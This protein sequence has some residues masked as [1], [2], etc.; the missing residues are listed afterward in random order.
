LSEAKSGRRAPDV[1]SLHPGYALTGKADITDNPASAERGLMRRG[2]KA[3]CSLFSFLR[4]LRIVGG[5]EN[6]GAFVR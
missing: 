4:K 5:I 3:L 6:K 1:A 2:Q